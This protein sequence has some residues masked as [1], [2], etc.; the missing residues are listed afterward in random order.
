M[1]SNNLSFCR[2]NLTTFAP[3]LLNANCLYACILLKVQSANIWGKFQQKHRMPWKPRA[4]IQAPTLFLPTGAGGKYSA[5]RKLSR[6]CQTHISTLPQA[7]LQTMTRHGAAQ[8]TLSRK[9]PYS[10]ERKSRLCLRYGTARSDALFCRHGFRPAE[11]AR[12]CGVPAQAEAEPFRPGSE[13]HALIPQGTAQAPAARGPERTMPER[14][15]NT[16]P[17]RRRSGQ[18]IP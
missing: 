1:A 7:R 17:S 3:Q 8:P 2:R 13:K 6:I 4:R 12:P 10:P 14:T 15:K 9:K 16:P 5:A 18:R 11:R